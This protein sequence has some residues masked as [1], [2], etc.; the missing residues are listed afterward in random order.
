MQFSCIFLITSPYPVLGPGPYLSTNIGP[1][2][3]LVLVL[4]PGPGQGFWSRHTV[5]IV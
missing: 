5:V 2:P 3:K 4:G 1:R